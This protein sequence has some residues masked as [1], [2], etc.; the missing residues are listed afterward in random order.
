[1]PELYGS[2]GGVQAYMRRLREIMSAYTVQAG[3]SLVCL[4]LLDTAESPTMHGDAGCSGEFASFG[5]S[6]A[7]LSAS[8]ARLTL[9]SRGGTM[10]VG[11]LGQ[12]P[13]ALGLKRAGLVRDYVVA[14]HGIEA[15]R[16]C[17]LLERSA[18]RAA[19]AVVATTNYTATEFAS[20]NGVDPSRM[21]VI[22]LALDAD[23]LS[24]P[25]F[26]E[27]NASALRV[28]TVGRLSAGERYKGMDTL[29]RAVRSMK[30][31]GVEVAL[32]IVGGGDDAPRL[33]ALAQELNV[34]PSVTFEG[35]VDDE[36]LEALYATT[37][38][39]ALLSRGEGFGIVFLE[40][41][42]HAKPCL[43]CRAGGVPE[44]VRDGIDGF[45]VEYGHV[46]RTCD[47]LT[48]LFEHPDLRRSLGE[49]GFRRVRST[50]LREHMRANWFRLL[51]G[52]A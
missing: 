19:S 40:A 34:E 30:E 1:M 24:E 50:F 26:G 45:L 21:Y 47:R 46:E 28:L 12:A 4:S 3:R 10:I 15:W 37:D 25:E 9:D 39:F 17:S 44:V 52:I 2:R 5:G 33:K 29:I 49:S 20:K 22:P 31:R 51:D 23:V 11:H 38:V 16:R 43:G 27:E 41:M 42:K 18:A 14:L 13:L 7:R 35:A 48:E 32:T 8:A 36:R 6:K